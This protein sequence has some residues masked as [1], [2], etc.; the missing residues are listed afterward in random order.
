MKDAI[1]RNPADPIAVVIGAVITVLGT[2]GIVD[3]LGLT[4]DEVT[5]LGGALVT[6]AAGI[7]T[8]LVHR[9]NRRHAEERAAPEPVANDNTTPIETGESDG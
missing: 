4:P 6:I 2:L 5:Q 8:I 7:R 9:G 1:R 3:K